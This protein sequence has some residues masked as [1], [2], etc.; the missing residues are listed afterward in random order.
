MST[1]FF[2]NFLVKSIIGFMILEIKIYEP[3]VKIIKIYE[4]LNISDAWRGLPFG[5]C[6]NFLGVRFDP[7]PPHY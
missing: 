1:C 5:D 7:V 6:L 4:K 3:A 2:L